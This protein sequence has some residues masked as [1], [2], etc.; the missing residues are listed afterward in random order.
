M[1]RSSVK[2]FKYRVGKNQILVIN[3]FQSAAAKADTGN[4]LASNAATVKIFK[5][6]KRR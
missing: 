5:K 1:V 2:T 3:I 6:E 4:A